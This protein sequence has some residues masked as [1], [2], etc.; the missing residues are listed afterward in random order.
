L[1]LPF[2]TDQA[3]TER[4]DRL[5]LPWNRFGIDPYGIAK[6][7]LGYFFTW[8]DKAYRSYFRCEVH[9]IEHVPAR[10]RAM[11]I[12]N[13]SG[14]VAIDAGMVLASCF[15]ELEPPRLAQ[16]MAEK[17]INRIPGAS[18]LTSRIGQFTGLP[19]HAKRLLEEERLLMV[20]PEGAR[21]TAKLAR[22]ADSLV[23]FGTGFMRLAMATGTPIVP[24]GFVGAGDAMPTIANLYGLG[25]LFGVPYIPVTSYLV[26]FPKPATFQILYGAPMHF[27]GE[28]SEADEVVVANVEKVRAR[29]GWLIEQGRKL[30]EGK[31]TPEELELT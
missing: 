9:G 30:R 17:F 11:L 31:M 29:I 20:F 27:S 2:L 7:E 26:P 15:F 5:E 12:S 18:Q 8:L 1:N 23:R 4:V 16:G 3:I 28:G 22:D 25:K 14:G 21:G 6:H 10:G 24:I 19:E 13:H